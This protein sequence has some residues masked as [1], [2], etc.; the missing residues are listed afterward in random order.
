MV[1]WSRPALANTEPFG[2]ESSA[3]T[4]Q[5]HRIL[6]A[7]P[8]FAPGAGKRSG[9]LDDYLPFCEVVAGPH[10]PHVFLLAVVEG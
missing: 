8:E 1:S 2:E 10:P 4:G 6:V 9:L 7:C 5:L 3:K